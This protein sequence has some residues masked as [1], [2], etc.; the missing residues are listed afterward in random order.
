[1]S[2]HGAEESSPHMQS[3]IDTR[4]QNPQIL[5]AWQISFNS[6]IVILEN[7]LDN[8]SIKHISRCKSKVCKMREEFV[9]Q[10]VLKDRQNCCDEFS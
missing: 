7:N 9:A 5:N 2:L 8:G 1:M 4:M 10:K 3:C 6:N